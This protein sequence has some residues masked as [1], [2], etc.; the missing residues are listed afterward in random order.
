MQNLKPILSTTLKLCVQRLS[1]AHPQSKNLLSFFYQ[2]VVANMAF[3]LGSSKLS[4]FVN[5]NRALN[6]RDWATAAKEMKNSRWFVPFQHMYELNIKLNK[7]RIE[8]I[9]QGGVY[10]KYDSWCHTT[11]FQA[12]LILFA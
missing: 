10:T 12:I 5:M 9:V 8:K 3:N 6:S 2:H 7:V 11:T 1:F 4:Q